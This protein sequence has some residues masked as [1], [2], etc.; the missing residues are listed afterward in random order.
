MIAPP[1]KRRSV[2]QWS[3]PRLQH[4]SSPLPVASTSS[5]RSWPQPARLRWHP[6]P[7]AAARRGH[8]TS[9]APP[10]L[11]GPWPPPSPPNSSQPVGRR[12]PPAG[13]QWR[14]LLSEQKQQG[15]LV[16]GQLSV[17]IGVKVILSVWINCY[18]ML[19]LNLRTSSIKTVI[20]TRDVCFYDLLC[21][22]FVSRCIKLM[23]WAE[24]CPTACLASQ[25]SMKYMSKLWKYATI[26]QNVAVTSPPR[27]FLDSSCRHQ[28]RA[29]KQCRPP[30]ALQWG[31][32]SSQL[33]WQLTVT[34]LQ[35]AL[36]W[37][38][39]LWLPLQLPPSQLWKAAS[40]PPYNIHILLM[41]CH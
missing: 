41:R 40:V 17:H 26:V 21:I 18:I 39:R 15:W 35:A 14:S 4:A 3:L 22:L 27:P 28:W 9:A 2:Q 12:G 34:N 24:C 13:P 38:Q 19:Y 36:N 31:S 8:R 20:L 37:R 7:W 30:V 32:S 11:R 16:Y 23:I 10:P 1:S 6:P 33:P 29:W 25:N 5:P